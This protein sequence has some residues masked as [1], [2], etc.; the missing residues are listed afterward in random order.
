MYIY[1]STRTMKS[2]T[3]RGQSI[4]PTHYT[5]GWCV[6]SQ[7]WVG[8]CRFALALTTCTTTTTIIT[9]QT[10]LQY[11]IPCPQNHHNYYQSHLC[12]G[13][14]HHGQHR[15]Q[16]GFTFSF[17]PQGICISRCSKD[18]SSPSER[19]INT[20]SMPIPTSNLRLSPR[21]YTSIEICSSIKP[22]DHRKL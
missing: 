2:Q 8:T 12:L 17:L 3:N 9:P 11:F 4:W 5:P 14:H 19:C 10:S 15:Q 22:R 7:G 18:D 13:L 20:C 6:K 21:H 1:S 16:R